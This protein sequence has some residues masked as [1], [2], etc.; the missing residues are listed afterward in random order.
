[1]K[2]GR[3]T[4]DDGG[5]AAGGSV[6]SCRVL[7]ACSLVALALAASWIGVR[8]G[9]TYDDRYIIEW[10]ARVHSLSGGQWWR[11]FGQ[12]YWPKDWGSDGYRPITM[13]L[14]AIEW[15]AGRGSPAVFHAVNIGLNAAASVAVF[16]LASLMLPTWAAW[17]AAALF[18]VHPVHVEAVA[19]VVGQ[20][21]LLVGL[22]LCVAVLV[23]V[24]A[25]RGGREDGST[26]GGLR[27]S[28]A[29]A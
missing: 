7:Q 1:M 10:N 11:L 4:T 2:D 5:R 22:A 15:V 28:S 25:R 12:S 26:E 24:K 19:N 27:A 6:L 18:A 23:Y 21:E 13:L 29:I 20:S 16:T 14:F 17:L 8:N 3:R 9:F